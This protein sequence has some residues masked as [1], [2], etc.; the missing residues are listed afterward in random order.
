MTRY[1]A[2]LGCAATAVTVVLGFPSL[3]AM[4][5]EES[6]DVIA[7]NLSVSEMDTVD[8]GV[9]YNADGVARQVKHY[10]VVAR[11]AENG[12]EVGRAPLLAPGFEDPDMIDNSCTWTVIVGVEYAE[13]YRLSFE[14]DD[15]G[16][17][18]SA[19]GCAAANTDFDYG[20]WSRDDLLMS[21]D[22]VSPDSDIEPVE[23]E[24]LGDG[25]PAVD[26]GVVEIAAQ[27]YVVSTWC[28]Y[29]FGDPYL[30]GGAYDGV[31]EGMLDRGFLKQQWSDGR[32][33][34]GG[35]C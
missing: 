4:A 20:P 32:I 21:G 2:L 11:N 18:P 34:T 12:V 31:T 9:L 23:E 13:E 30:N 17:C 27:P 24:Y 6:L 22:L 8:C 16:R 29:P 5:S 7:K 35:S 33:T 1:R 10:E 15:E 28:D 26:P 3:T 25:S 14:D 19:R